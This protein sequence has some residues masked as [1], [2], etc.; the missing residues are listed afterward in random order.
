MRAEHADALLEL[1]QLRQLQPGQQLRLPDQDD[2]QDLLLGGLEVG[3]Q[4]DLLEGLGVEVLG[5]VE[6]E[7]RVLAGP[8]PLDQEVLERDEPLHVGGSPG[9]SISKSSSM[10]SRMPSNGSVELET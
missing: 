7:H 6:D 9:F 2:L 8:V 3:E 5:L 1:A 10:Y 4:P